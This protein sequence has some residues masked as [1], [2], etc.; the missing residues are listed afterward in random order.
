MNKPRRNRILLIVAVAV[1][2]G[3]GLLLLFPSLHRPATAAVVQEQDA[4]TVPEH[5][6][7][8]AKARELLE[9]TDAA[10]MAKEAMDLQM[11]QMK[12]MG[13]QVPPGFFEAFRD[14]VDME[15]LIDAIAEVYARHLTA[16][17]MQAAIDFYNTPAGR[18]FAA[19][20][21]IIMQESGAAGEALGQ[22]W[23][24]Q[25]MENLQQ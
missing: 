20:Q 2:I 24:V 1:L 15:A 22:K 25:A 4:A 21:G 6:D 3:T 11:E 16:A 23:A 7:A 9:L 13:L 10:T 18:S 12:Q 14:E 19:K 17:E 5:E 8:L